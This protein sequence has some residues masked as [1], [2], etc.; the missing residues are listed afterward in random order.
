M[1]AEA[2]LVLQGFM[3]PTD[4]IVES[5]DEDSLGEE[6][7]ESVD[8]EE[9]EDSDVESVIAH[10][11]FE[12]PTEFKP[13]ELKVRRTRRGVY[14]D[15]NNAEEVKNPRGMKRG[16]SKLAAKDST[17]FI[18]DLPIVFDL[19]GEACGQYKLRRVLDQGVD[20]TEWTSFKLKT[21]SFF[22]ETEE[23]RY[24]LSRQLGVGPDG[25]DLYCL[26]RVL[27]PYTLTQA[28][29][30]T[31]PVPLSSSHTRP[32]AK[33]LDWA[34]LVWSHEGLA[35]TAGA[36]AVVAG[37]ASKPSGSV[38]LK[39]RSL[40]MAKN[41]TPVTRETLGA[42]TDEEALARRMEEVR[43]KRAHLS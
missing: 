4:S 41:G 6:H 17:E 27:A 11:A 37:R 13:E 14:K 31:L 16:R 32:L 8:D 33:D 21:H 23:G 2:Q 19:A 22:M 29:M 12:V 26:K 9:E 15:R 5:V 3:S 36:R 38:T 20:Y 1:A 39:L 43:S 25:F 10:K 7:P 34:D 30:S 42:E 40:R 24:E 28:L 35:V 18:P